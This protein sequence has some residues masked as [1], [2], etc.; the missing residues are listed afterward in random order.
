[1][2]II[3]FYENL[4]S[5]NGY[6]NQ[7]YRQKFIHINQNLTKREQLF[8]V[9][10]EL[11]HSILHPKSNTMFLSGKT[12]FSVN[13]LEVQANKFAM[14]LLISDEELLE[15]P[16]KTLDQLTCIFGYDKK[17]IQLRL[18]EFKIEYYLELT[19]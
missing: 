18:D 19:E 4:G 6:Y 2:N 11:G 5:I 9:A 14:C 8:T 13:K 1:M 12:L 15:Y 7:L 10:H 17:L 3:I 16:N